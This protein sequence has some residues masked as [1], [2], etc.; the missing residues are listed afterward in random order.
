MGLNADGSEPVGQP[1]QPKIPVH[2]F[3]AAG[4]EVVMG[5]L[6]V[7]QVKTALDMDATAEA[8]FDAIVALTPSGGSALATAQKAQ[9]VESMHSV[10]ILA[11]GRYATYNTAAAVRTKL[12]I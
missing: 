10:F 1:D 12:G 11:E 9:F 7:A 4:H 3:F 8:E 2:D 5:R 6:T